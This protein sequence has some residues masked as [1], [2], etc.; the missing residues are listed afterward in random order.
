MESFDSEKEILFL[1]TV[2]EAEEEEQR[3]KK[4]K[5]WVHEINCKRLIFGKPISR[6]LEGFEEV[7]E[8][9]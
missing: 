5:M 8:I 9:L 6:S 4:K 1:A 3:S 7:F 2:V